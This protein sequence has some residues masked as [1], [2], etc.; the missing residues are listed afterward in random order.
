MTIIDEFEKFLRSA[1]TNNEL[2]SDKLRSAIHVN[3]DLEEA[4][5]VAQRAGRSIIIAGTAGSGKSHLL[6]VAG[7]DTQYK[8]IPDLTDVLEQQESLFTTPKIVVAANEGALLI[9]KR[10]GWQYFGDIVATLHALQNGTTSTLNEFVVI[11]AAAYNPSGLNIIAKLLALPVVRELVETIKYPAIKLSWDVL[12]GDNSLA[13]DRLAALVAAAS[14]EGQPFT[15][16]M[17]WRFLADGLLA[18][19]RCNNENDQWQALS[20]SALWTS[21]NEVSKRLAKLEFESPLVV[22]HLLGHYYYRNKTR[23]IEAVDEHFVSHLE[24]LLALS[25]RSDEMLANGKRFIV[26]T[27]R[28]NYV[29]PLSTNT[30]WS[31]IQRREVGPII[32]AINRYMSHNRVTKAT[33]LDLWVQHDTER[34]QEKPEFQLALGQEVK[35]NFTVMRSSVLHAAD[36]DVESPPGERYYLVH[37]PS[38]SRLRLDSEFS[39]CLERPRSRQTSDRKS[40]ETDWRLMRFFNQLIPY[41]DVQVSTMHLKVHDCSPLEWQLTPLLGRE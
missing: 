16:R 39:S 10:N 18:A 7:Q 11:D 15:F 29:T 9:G 23:L 34:R 31:A 25:N 33:M 4:V 35:A 38:E 12:V 5:R 28:N 19:L 21:N 13:R 36:L 41:A 20:Y 14:S 26:L 37:K 6:S 8:I 27:S 24:S 1:G 17:I 32:A 40:V 30:L 2:L 22:P 3:S